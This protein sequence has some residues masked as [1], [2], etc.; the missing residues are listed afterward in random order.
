MDL[1]DY[2]S[3][4]YTQQFQYKSFTPSLINKEWIWTE[5]KINTLL[6]EAN[7][8]LGELNAFSLYVPDVD[9]FIR[10]HIVK[11]ATT[12]S[13]I[14]GTRTEVEEVVLKEEDIHPE[15]KD[16][17][18]EVQNYIA[19]MNYAV[20]QLMT[21][22][23][24][25]RLLK[26]THR[27]LMTGARGEVKLPGEFRTSQNWIGGSSIKDAVFIPP[28]HSEV[29]EQMGDLE[30]FL[31]NDQI[32]VPPLVRV[33]IAHCQ[34]ET[35]HPFLD[36]NGRI[37]RLLITLYLV[38]Q[39]LM[40]KPTLYLSAYLERH[41]SVYYDNLMLVRTSNN[42]TQWIKFFLVAVIETSKDGIESFRQILRLRDEIEGKKILSL[43]KKLPKAKELMTLLYT[44]PAVSS[45]HIAEKLGISI[46]TANAL[47]Q[48]FVQLGILRETTGAKRNRIFLF[49]DY[50][51][52][53]H[54][55]K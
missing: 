6:A 45:A 30:N 33:A 18:K 36:G 20:E 38:N 28:H 8:K 48:D 44:S 19:A 50:L 3:G 12:S 55:K 9:F 42:L 10:M 22:P 40:A 2:I 16:D 35:I 41:K 25:T 53:F 54:D 26:E 4:G 51:K 5:P 15:K 14:E 49:Y 31:H 29:G 47:I 46:P 39:K 34:F 23:V 11:E 32:N 27:I 24:S 37:G 43:G 13:R 17:W 1:K 52:L 21:L 7:L